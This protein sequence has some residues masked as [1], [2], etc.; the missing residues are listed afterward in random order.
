MHSYASRVRGHGELLKEEKT[1]LA[2]ANRALIR[3]QRGRLGAV[4]VRHREPAHGR[5]LQ[6]PAHD[7]VGR[8]FK[9]KRCDVGLSLTTSAVPAC[10]LLI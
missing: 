4:D 10:F 2:R 6:P 9:A 1:V 8:G 5:E 3:H 7:P